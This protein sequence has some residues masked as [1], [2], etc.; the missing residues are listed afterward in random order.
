ML[1]GQTTQCSEVLDQPSTVQGRMAA[2]TY[3]AEDGV[4][5]NGRGGP[6]SCGDLMPQ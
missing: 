6:W 1:A 2:D 5:T 3:V 4:V